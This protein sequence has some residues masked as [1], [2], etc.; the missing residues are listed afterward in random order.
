MGVGGGGRGQ[1]PGS[2]DPGKLGSHG[3]REG[4]QPAAWSHVQPGPEPDRAARAQPPPALTSH[5]E[6][7]NTPH[8]SAE[9]KYIIR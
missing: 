2:R 9:S 4:V 8:H 5:S 3:R 7:I 1:G 6:A